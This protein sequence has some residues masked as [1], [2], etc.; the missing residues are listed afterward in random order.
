[1]IWET[2]P[3]PFEEAGTIRC[4]TPHI[5]CGGSIP[6]MRWR[7]TRAAFSCNG[8]DTPHSL[9]PDRMRV[10]TK[11]EGWPQSQQSKTIGR[12]QHTKWDEAEYKG[13]SRLALQHAFLRHL[14]KIAHVVASLC[15][16]AGNQTGGPQGLPNE[17]KS[18]EKSYVQYLTAEYRI[19]WNGKT[20]N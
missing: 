4:L 17:A 9:Y 7:F 15:L 3:L 5:R 6:H 12:E 16:I 14:A 1:M 13:R 11:N 20:F 8:K 10:R 2:I 19:G 18:S